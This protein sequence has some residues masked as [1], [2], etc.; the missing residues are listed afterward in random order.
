MALLPCLGLLSLISAQTPLP[1][2]QR[3]YHIGNSVTD[4]IRYPAL[5]QMAQGAGLRYTYGRHMIPGAPLAWIHAHPSDGFKEET[6]WY[7]EALKNHIWDVITL[8]P[9]DRHLEGDDGDV[10]MAVKFIELSRAKSPKARILIYSRWPRKAQDGSLDYPLFWGKTY[11]GGWDGTN[12][13]RD[14]FLKLLKKLK[15]ALPADANRLFIVPVGD[16]LLS[17]D[18]KLNAKATA[19]LSGVNDLYTDGIHFGDKGAFVVGTTFY[20]VLF[21]RSPLGLSGEAYGVRDQAFVK[22]VQ[23]TVWDVVS[24]DPLTGVKSS[25]SG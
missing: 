19:G 7:P 20:S 16:V 6:G 3:V 18:R 10:V 21:K 8:Q 17:L 12:E 25:A 5:A 13:T 23:E 9:F 15:Q 2:E 4:T 24:K 22:L 14:Y 1:V 11:T